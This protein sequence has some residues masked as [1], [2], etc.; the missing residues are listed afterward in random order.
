MSQKIKA[1]VKKIIAKNKI[2][3]FPIPLEKILKSYKI[4][5]NYSILEDAV[6]GFLYNKDGKYIIS[7]NSRHP[8]VRQRFTIAHELGHYLLNHQGD[9]FID[10]G[11]IFRDFRSSTGN[12]RWEKEAN[13]FAAELLMP[14]LMLERFINSEKIEDD[15]DLEIVAQKLVVST[16]S[17]IYRLDNLG[18]I[19]LY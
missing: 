18:L 13:K 1:I 16:Q 4:G 7:V 12:I 10:K 2:T 14:Q 3:D 15:E 9:L 6:S 11:Y 8:I 19:S 5:L 17:L